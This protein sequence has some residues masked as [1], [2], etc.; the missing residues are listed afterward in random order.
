MPSFFAMFAVSVLMGGI[1]AAEP[2]VHMTLQPGEQVEIGHEVVSPGVDGVVVIPAAPD[3]PTLVEITGPQAVRLLLV[4]GEA[5]PDFA[6]DELAG[7]RGKGYQLAELRGPCPLP[8]GD[9]LRKIIRQA[10]QLCRI[11]AG[12][13][14]VG[15]TP[16]QRRATLVD[17]AAILIRVS[18]ASRTMQAVWPCRRILVA[19]D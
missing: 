9:D 10:Q 6:A 12:A 5:R 16:T 8:E 2:S 19:S 14:L 15:N 3:R 1:A 4:P 11:A 7:L 17:P 13:S 18:L